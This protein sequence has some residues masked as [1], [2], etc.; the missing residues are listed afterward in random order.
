MIRRA[1]LAGCLALLCLPAGAAALELDPVELE[2]FIDGAVG[3]QLQ[4]G[5]IAGA[6]VSVVAGGRVVLAKGYG[7]TDLDR[8]QAVEASTTLFRPGSIS[9]LITWTAVMQLVE[10]G[11]LDLDSDVNVYLE[12]VEVPATFPE[13]ITLKHLMTH[14][15]GFEDRVI[16][17]FSRDPD[18]L[19]PLRELMR[20]QM[21][22]RVR[23]P[24]QIAAYSN[25]GT[26]L[27]GLIV[28]QVSG[29]PFQTYVERRIFEPLGMR[30]STFAQPLPPRLAS[31]MSG[32]YAL[33]GGA[34]VARPFELVPAAPAGGMSSTATDMA[35]FMLA[36]LGDGALG[37]ARILQAA[38]ARRMRERLH[39]HDPQ[40][41]GMAHGFI[42]L[43][44]NG[45][46]VVGHLGDTAYFHSVLALLPEQGLGFFASYNS[47]TGS[48]SAI[49]LMRLLIGH[50][51]PQAAPLRPVPPAGSAQRMQEVA[52][53]YAMSRVPET[54]HAKVF[55]L[56]LVVPVEHDGDA[57]VLSDPLFGVRRF[58]E[59]E[60]WVFR[61]L[62]G[63][64]EIRFQRDAG[65]KVTRML[66]ANLPI[67]TFERLGTW[68]TPA[69]QVAL[70]GG[71]LVLLASCLVVWPLG[72]LRGAAR[73][74]SPRG[75]L[76][77]AAG[78]ATALLYVGFVACFAAGVSDFEALMFGEAPLV[79]VSFGFSLAAA[80][81]TPLLVAGAW[82]VW[83]DPLERRASR[84][85][86]GLVVLAALGWT[87]WLGHWNLIGP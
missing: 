56:A 12:G 54:S 13:P 76:A 20:L 41:N 85:Y 19:L 70:G 1:A 26:A 71:L 81:S 80:L 65:G 53:V 48:R 44:M 45:Q 82:S 11:K 55:Q 5:P 78:V 69:V 59:V 52:G 23:P 50:L 27:A 15:P 62:H 33:V 60:P 21:P 4:Q 25:H 75:R 72:V 87:L 66:V 24:G 9:K 58:V 17:L 32:G 40:V 10:E 7:L 84:G 34:L 2:G 16:G 30:D 39:A 51:F 49:G 79:A 67:M 8:G 64:D 28:E 37:D 57:L 68:S 63:R 22:A 6:V 86:Y 47:A 14:T 36:Q 74:W 38:T 29:V 77:R 18:D 3:L 83:R 43:D 31:R 35:R 42:E 73:A 61:E 46:R